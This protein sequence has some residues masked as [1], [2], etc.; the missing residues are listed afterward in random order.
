MLLANEREIVLQFAAPTDSVEAAARSVRRR[1]LLVGSVSV[2]GAGGVG[3]LAAAFALAP[4]ARLR[5]EADRV[6]ETV[7]LSV[8]VPAG[9]GPAGV[10]ELGQTFKPH[11]GAESVSSPHA[12]KRH[13]T[14]RAPSPPTRRTSCARR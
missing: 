9:Q 11:A 12:R 8:R 3:W 10:D 4:L 14:P 1:V 5:R 13:C 7:D 2:L 6:S